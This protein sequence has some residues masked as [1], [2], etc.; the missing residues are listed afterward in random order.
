DELNGAWVG[1]EGGGTLDGVEGGDASAGSGSD[2]DEAPT[3]AEGGSDEIDGT[4][5]L[6]QSAGHGEGD[7]D[8]F[9]VDE[10]RDL[11][12]RFLVEVEGGVVGLL[13]AEAAESGRGAFQ[14]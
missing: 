4:R 8:V 11:E 10:G 13:G 5:D 14:I 6:R 2:V 7:G 3:A 9:G 12:G 1:V